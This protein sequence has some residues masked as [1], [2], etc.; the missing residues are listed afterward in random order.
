DDLF[1]NDPFKFTLFTNKEYEW[2]FSDLPCTICSSVYDAL[3]QRLKD[4]IKVLQM[5]WAKPYSF[6]RRLGNGISVFNPGDR[7]LKQVVVTNEMLQNRINRIFGD[8]NQVHYLFSRYAKTNNGLYALMDIK[9][10]NIE[11]L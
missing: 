6:N 11:R 3:L 4:P 9:S 8:S 10:H 1:K 2:V 7:P 5:L